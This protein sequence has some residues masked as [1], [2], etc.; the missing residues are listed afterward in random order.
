LTVQFTHVYNAAKGS[1]KEEV[2]WPKR[3]GLLILFLL[4]NPFIKNSNKCWER[5]FSL[6]SPIALQLI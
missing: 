2:S 1:D 5:R 6:Q 3:M 4:E